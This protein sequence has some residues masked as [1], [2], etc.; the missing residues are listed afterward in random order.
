MLAL[1]ILRLSIESNKLNLVA[2]LMIKGNEKLVAK[3]AKENKIKQVVILKFEVSI[4]L[5]LILDYLNKVKFK[6][7]TLNK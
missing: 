3:N 7:I 5:N 6:P 2:I 1:C 4:Y